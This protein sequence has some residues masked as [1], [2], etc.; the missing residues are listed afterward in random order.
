[1]GVQKTPP[2]YFIFRGGTKNS[3]TVDGGHGQQLLC[4]IT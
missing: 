1:V 4:S 2:L 3:Q